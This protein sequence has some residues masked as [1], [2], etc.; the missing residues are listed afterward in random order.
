[1]QQTTNYQLNHWEPE[2]RVTRADFNADNAKLDAALAGLQ[3]AVAGAASFVTGS[4]SGNDSYP[5]TITL[6]FR[7]KAVIFSTVAGTTFYTGQC[8]GGVLLSNRALAFSGT[9]FAQIT[10]DG[11]SLVSGKTNDSQWYYNYIAFK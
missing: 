6:G 2:D 9:T 7:P 4:Y 5:R 1:M 8:Y 3:T 11:F 10:D